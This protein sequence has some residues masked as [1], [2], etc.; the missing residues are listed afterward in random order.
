MDITSVEVGEEEGGIVGKPYD[1]ALE[2]KQEG[3]V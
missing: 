1:E 3:K 2:V